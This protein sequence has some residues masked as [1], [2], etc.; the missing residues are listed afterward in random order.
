[1][2]SINTET[3]ESGIYV[4][5]MVISSTARAFDKKDKSGIA[6][7]VTHELALQPGIAKWE[8]YHEPKVGHIEVQDGEVTKFPRLEE[9]KPIVLKVGRVREFNGTVSL[10]NAEVIE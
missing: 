4:K 6:I 8:E 9:F 3:L 5:G 10:S 1:M 7:R 2:K